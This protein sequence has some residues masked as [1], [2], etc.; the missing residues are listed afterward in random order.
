MR[1]GARLDVALDDAAKLSCSTSDAPHSATVTAV[2]ATADEPPA[3]DTTTTAAT[4]SS[5]DSAANS[6]SNSSAD[7]ALWTDRQDR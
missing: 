3:L 7:V 6:A 1:H 4:Y 5:T 2:T